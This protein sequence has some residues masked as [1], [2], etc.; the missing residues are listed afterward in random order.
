MTRNEAKYW[1]RDFDDLEDN[2]LDCI[3]R[4]GDTPIR[5]KA[6]EASWRPN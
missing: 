5:R 6:N 4:E 2:Y 3:A 1:S